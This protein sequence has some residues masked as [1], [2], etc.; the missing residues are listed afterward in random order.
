MKA[1]GRL[2]PPTRDGGA[3][4][5]DGLALRA[6]LHEQQTDHGPHGVPIPFPGGYLSGHFLFHHDAGLARRDF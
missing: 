3:V 2:I 6:A 1:S 4:S 5:L